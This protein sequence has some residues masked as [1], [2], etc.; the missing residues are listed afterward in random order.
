MNVGQARAGGDVV[1]YPLGER[2]RLRLGDLHKTIT[3]Q[4]QSW[5][6]EI[7]LQGFHLLVFIS[8]VRPHLTLDILTE[9]QI[10]QYVGV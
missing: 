9:G 6:E 2:A 4:E 8:G 10:S 7:S 3:A 5:L 1:L